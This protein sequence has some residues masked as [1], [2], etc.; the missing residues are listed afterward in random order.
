LFAGVP[1]LSCS[2]LPTIIFGVTQNQWGSNLIWGSYFG[3]GW[4][5]SAFWSGGLVHDRFSTTIGLVW[6]WLALVPL[7]LVAGKF[8][9][10]SS[11]Q[12]RRTAVW[13]LAVSVLPMVPART[14]LALDDY[15]IHLPDYGLHLNESF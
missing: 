4:C 9:D 2:V 1:L 6:S 14:L 5:L 13:L 12:G 3:L 15:G 8:W 7:Y 11:A 10:R